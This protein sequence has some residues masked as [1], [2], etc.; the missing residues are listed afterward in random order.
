MILSVIL[1]STLFANS[2]ITNFVTRFYTTVLERN[3][4][5]TGLN[6]W[7][8]QLE[9]GTKS[10]S[11]IAVGF[12][13]STEFKNRNVDNET[14]LKILYRS[15]F[16]REGD[17]GGISN[18]IN[19]LNSGS[20]RAEILDGFLTS[21]EFLNLC[22]TY[23]IK[24]NFNDVINFVTR[25]YQ[26]VLN[27]NPD[28][29]GLN[30]WVQHLTR[31]TKGGDD[32]AKGFISSAEFINRNVSN[33][34]YLEILY[35]SFF[36]RDGDS[37][38]ISNWMNKLN[39]GSSKSEVLDG[40]LNST[41][42][43]NLCKEY[44]IKPT[45]EWEEEIVYPSNQ[46]PIANIKEY[47][48][49]WPP[50]FVRGD[51][52]ILD[53]S[54]SSDI[55][56]EI[57]DYEWSIISHP[58][59]KIQNANSKQ[60]YF[61][62]QGEPKNT[63]AKDIATIYTI[64]LKVTDNYG[65]TNEATIK[66]YE[67]SLFRLPNDPTIKRNSILSADIVEHN[68]ISYSLIKSKNTNR[69]WLTTNIGTPYNCNFCDD[70]KKYGQIYDLE[71]ILSFDN[72]KICPI[73]F[74]LPTKAE[75]KSEVDAEGISNIYKANAS[76]LKLPFIYNENYNS[77]I[78]SIMTSSGESVV[79]QQYH[80]NI[81][82]NSYQ[83]GII[84]CIQKDSKLYE[85]EG[86]WSLT[87]NN[88]DYYYY[89]NHNGN[90]IV[91]KNTGSCYAV[92]T[93][94]QLVVNSN[95]HYDIYVDGEKN[96]TESAI[97]QF[98]GTTEFIWNNEPYQPL[99]LNKEYSLID[100]YSFTVCDD[101][102]IPISNAGSD[103]IV[104][105]N[106]M[107]SLNGSNSYDSDGSIVKYQWI[108]TKGIS[109]T[110]NSPNNSKPYFTAPNV[111][112]DSVLE[113]KLI[114]TDNDGATSED[115]VEVTVIN[116]IN[117]IQD[118]VDRHNEIRGE[119]YSGSLI[120]WNNGIAKSAQDYAD[121]LASTGEFKHGNSDYG[122]NLFLSSYN[123]S[124]VDAINSWYEEKSNYDYSDNSCNGVCGHYTQIIWKNSTELGCAKA[125][126]STGKYKDYTLI[127][128]RYNPVGNYTSQKP[129]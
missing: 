38:G 122:E 116:E 14:Y 90:Y 82:W 129:Y 84:R 92:T 24:P 74:K 58:T 113:F 64:K 27:R 123:S 99:V 97:I 114:V 89:F 23:G 104:N 51:K 88:I 36:N 86:Y 77:K 117:L 66:I 111:D 60:A 29:A 48:N 41:E 87:L 46:L 54:L 52:I 26:K 118:A 45:K 105:E 34:K 100:G 3:P 109:I 57:V 12:I 50:N 59:I 56:G 21:Q 11:D 37:G 20:S 8:K 69:N 75:F 2:N 40:F 13:F 44:G 35:K 101:K 25:F 49:N 121:Y 71:D 93:G 68:N 78:S 1:N 70:I 33:T 15:F 42:F 102:K 124:S 55:D 5:T 126:Y 16:D 127:V 32:I 112:S 79:F 83:D 19:K 120:E 18:W 96:S 85:L 106:S 10:G 125:T 108:Q 98:N 115:F 103:I 63:T 62:A 128:C 76:F 39:S 81:N 53:G 94:H 107:I 73:N 91:Y 4:D 110:L 17:A 67:K 9:N 7:V 61:I 72:Y 6:N 43:I 30:N 80:N 65:D 119:V 31:G 95:G 28:T 47:D 22:S